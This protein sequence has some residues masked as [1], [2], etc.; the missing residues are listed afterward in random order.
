[1]KPGEG[2]KELKVEASPANGSTVEELSRIELV[3]PDYSEVAIGSGYPTL[4]K[5]GGEP[6]RLNDAEYDWDVWNKLILNITPAVT[7]AGNYL[8]SFPE[9]YVLDPAGN[10]LPGFTLSYTVNGQSGIGHI[11]INGQS[12]DAV[13]TTGGVRI[14]ATKQPLPAGVYIVNGKKV[15]M[16]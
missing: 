16:K 15:V 9:G 8:I 7:E 13:Y 6:S 12:V 11:Q 4:S 5:D 14:R 1:M 10:G 3:F 2:G